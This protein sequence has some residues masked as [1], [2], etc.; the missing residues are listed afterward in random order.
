MLSSQDREEIA[1]KKF[2]LIAPVLNGQ[3]ESGCISTAD[4][5]WRV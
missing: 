4:M 2:A 1:L 3:V 5:A